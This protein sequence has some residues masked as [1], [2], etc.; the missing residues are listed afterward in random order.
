VDIWTILLDVVILLAACLLA[1]GIFSRLGQSPLLGYLLAGMF[2]G[3]P[4]SFGAF[5]QERDIEA[6]A[7]LGVS[8]LLFSLGLEFSWRRLRSLGSR[9]LLSGVFQVVIT[10]VSMTA[11]CTVFRVPIR[12]AVALGAMIALSSTACCLRVLKETGQLDSVHGRTSLAILLVQD[13]AVVPLAILMT[14]LA[15][16][17]SAA[18]V[19]LSVAKTVALAIAL[20]TAMFLLLNKLA[21][22]A[23]GRLTLERNRELTVLLAVVTALGSAWASH[24]AGLS[25]ALGAF[26]AGL[27][28]GGSPF[29]T[30]IRADVSSLRVVLL[31][32]F[33]GAA[34]MVADPIWIFEHL[35]LVIGV[36]AAIM[37]GK[38]LLV[39]MITRIM[40]RSDAVGVATGLC[41]SQ[42]GEFAL[43][44][45]RIGTTSGVVSGETY[46]LVISC[47]IFTLFLTPFLIPAAPKLGVMFAR[48]VLGR[49]ADRSGDAAEARES[50]ADV[51]IIGFGPAGR[52]V[53]QALSGLKLQVDVVDLNRAA[54]ESAK[55][56][57][58]R[59]HVGDATQREVMEHIGI[60]SSRLVVV[61]I[62]DRQASLIIVEEV[63]RLARRA[64]V[65]VRCRS[66]RYASE[67]KTAGAHEVV[68]E[69]EQVGRRLAAVVRARI[70]DLC[71]IPP[72][73]DNGGRGTG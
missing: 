17:G 39:W 56:L 34:G 26:V 61:T 73:D 11:V 19:A 14:L 42:I 60:E 13:L 46:K 21:V 44:L 29:A 52:R 12:E 28:L 50:A 64:R 4:G 2:L 31:T 36:S 27:F 67:F 41:V 58:L 66:D 55:H 30:Q 69:E 48:R 24:S 51:V 62:P 23:L 32:L 45:G 3:G 16:T 33:F 35:R 40:G 7:E 72:G 57:G 10:A 63:R 71:E 70:R 15:G 5:Q 54:G 65:V 38:A 1:G 37:T 8:L 59:F 68:E 9:T 43:V 25:P 6:I 49:K 47:T 20:V 22:A 53:G 18:E